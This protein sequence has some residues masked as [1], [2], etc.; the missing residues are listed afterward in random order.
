MAAVQS[1][2]VITDNVPPVE[3]TSNPTTSTQ[4]ELKEDKLWQEEVNR[5]KAPGEFKH[6][7]VLKAVMSCGGCSGAIDRR[8]KKFKTGKLPIMVF[9]GS[10]DWVKLM[11][12]Y[13]RLCQRGCSESR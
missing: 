13:Y 8:L 5:V 3:T 1:L 9:S 4:E 10:E 6:H 7:F 12:L 11:R 2:P